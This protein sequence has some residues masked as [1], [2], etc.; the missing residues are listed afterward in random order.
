LVLRHPTAKTLKNVVTV[1]SNEYPIDVKTNWQKVKPY[2][3]LIGQSVPNPVEMGKTIH[4]QL[5]AELLNNSPQTAAENVIAEITLPTEVKFLGVT[6]T[7]GTCELAGNT[8][9]CQLGNLSIVNSDDVS[10]V[11]IDLD[12]E[13]ADLGLLQ[14]SAE[15]RVYAN[16]LPE[17][18]D[19]IRTALLLADVQV[20]GAILL[21]VTGSM[22]EELQSVIKGVKKQ[23]DK[24]YAGGKSPL[25]ALVSFRDSVKLEA[26]STDFNVLLKALGK[27]EAKGGG[28]CA[29]A[30]AEALTLALNHVKPGGTI[31]FASDAPPYDGTDIQALKAE[32]TAKQAV[33]IPILTKSDCAANELAQ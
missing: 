7:Q 1:T 23:L 18:R 24:E 2:L 20:D 9:I 6:A 22:G 28:L 31:V 3:S 11:T 25:I 32:I 19:V 4:Y 8:V 21:D 14:L 27:L 33:F 29:E 26:V 10:R 13:L 16:N 15:T 17:H 12:V 5:T 30:S